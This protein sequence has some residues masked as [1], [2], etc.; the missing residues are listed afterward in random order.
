MA[1][2]NQIKDT[3]LSA[4]EAWVKKLQGDQ[5]PVY[6]PTGIPVRDPSSQMAEPPMP[7]DAAD[8]IRSGLIHN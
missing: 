2:Q 4:M 3:E 6:K 8:A 1:D 5:P 7:Q